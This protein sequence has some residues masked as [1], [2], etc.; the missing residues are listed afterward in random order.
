MKTLDNIIE[1]LVYCFV[2]SF[3]PSHVLS[4]GNALGNNLDV[5][6]SCVHAHILLKD[7][8]EI[9]VTSETFQQKKKISQ[10]V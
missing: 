3:I 6:H 4:S 2:R 5:C 10:Q 8:D 9:E 1:I 7:T